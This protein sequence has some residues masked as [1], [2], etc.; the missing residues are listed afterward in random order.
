MQTITVANE[1]HK[2]IDPVFRED[3]RNEKKNSL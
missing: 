2:D 1:Y 3:V